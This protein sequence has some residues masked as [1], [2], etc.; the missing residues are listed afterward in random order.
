MTLHPSD[1][2]HFETKNLD[3]DVLPD[4]ALE[5]LRSKQEK[6]VPCFEEGTG[7]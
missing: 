7:E 5:V 3:L 1:H 6:G 2:K 4:P